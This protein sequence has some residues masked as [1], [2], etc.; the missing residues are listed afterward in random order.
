[1]I[2]KSK[3]EKV[4]PHE[5]LLNTR[6]FDEETLIR[7][8]GLSI[9][10][11]VCLMFAVEFLTNVANRRHKT[12]ESRTLKTEVDKESNA[13]QSQVKVEEVDEQ[14]HQDERDMRA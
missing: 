14:A 13:S 8:F 7:S 3:S 4:L 1:V 6:L 12:A 9:S 11:G 2:I 5:V 10:T